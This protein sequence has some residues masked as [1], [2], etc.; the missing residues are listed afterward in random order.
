MT[1]QQGD[2]AM[3]LEFNEISFELIYK[4]GKQ[5]VRGSQVGAALGYTHARR[6]IAK[7]YARNV[8]EFSADMTITMPVLD[9]A[10][11]EDEEDGAQTDGAAPPCAV[12]LTAQVPANAESLGGQVREVRLFS[13]RGAHLLAM[14]ARTERAKDFRRWVLDVLE[15]ACSRA[16]AEPLTLAQEMTLIRLSVSLMEKVA[17]CKT[18][19]MAEELFMRLMRVNRRLGVPTMPFIDLATSCRQRRLPLGDGDLGAGTH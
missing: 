7:L 1:K 4:D 12:N 15:D 6:S 10:G 19:D 16:P 14:L 2:G 9:L 11:G 5:W 3:A 17:A 13:A 8:D 18:M